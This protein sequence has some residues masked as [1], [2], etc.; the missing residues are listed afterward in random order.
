METFSTFKTGDQDVWDADHD[1]LSHHS[2]PNQTSAN[3]LTQNVRSAKILQALFTNN[4]IVINLQSEKW[5]EDQ[6]NVFLFNM[7]E[8]DIEIL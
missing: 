6:D 5:D 3:S 1:M 2:E 4:I 7:E 8:T